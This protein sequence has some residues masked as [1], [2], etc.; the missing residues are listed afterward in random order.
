MVSVAKAELGQKQD[1]GTP[2]GFSREMTGCLYAGARV[3]CFP[4]HTSSDL[5]LKH[6]NKLN[7]HS[8]VEWLLY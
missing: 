3:L 1:S 6:S 2:S 7:W 5:D 8:D 4:K